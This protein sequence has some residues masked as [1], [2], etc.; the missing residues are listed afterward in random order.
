MMSDHLPHRVLQTLG[1]LSRPWRIAYA[2]SS[3]SGII[4]AVRAGLGVTL[5]ARSTVPQDVRVL[6]NAKACR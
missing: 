4:A 1:R 6:G 3:Y 2:S 5:L